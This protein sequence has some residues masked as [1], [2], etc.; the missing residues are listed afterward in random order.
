MPPEPIAWLTQVTGET[1][2]LV[3]AQLLDRSHTTIYRW[4][5]HGM[6]PPEAVIDIAIRCN[7]DVIRALVDNGWLNEREAD[8]VNLDD[9]LRRLPAVKLTAEIHRRAQARAKQKAGSS[10]P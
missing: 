6:I 2:V 9:T 5:D 10:Q 1:R 7:V 4:R 8:A 3:I